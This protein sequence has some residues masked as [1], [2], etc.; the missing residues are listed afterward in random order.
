[1]SYAYYLWGVQASCCYQ[2]TNFPSIELMSQQQILQEVSQ[3]QR[4]SSSE[5]I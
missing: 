1:M 2:Y 5:D 3:M 4:G